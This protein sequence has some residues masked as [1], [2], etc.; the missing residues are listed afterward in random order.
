MGA[1]LQEP[2][3]RIIGRYAIYDQIAS[4]GMAVVHFGRLLGQAGFSRTVAVKRLHP[5]FAADPDFVAMFLDEA[6]LS[7]RVQHP[8]VVAPLDVVVADGELLVIMD[9]VSGETL[10]QLIR[11]TALD[12]EVAPGII[13]SVLVDSLYGLHAAH[14]AL[15]EDGAPLS[16]VHRDVSPQNIIVGVDG[17]ARVLDFGVAKAAMRS[18]ATKDGEIKGKIAYMAPEQLRSQPLDRRADVFAAGVVL[19]EALTGRRLFR[20]DDLG[21]TIERVL[22]AKVPLPSSLNP[23]VPAALDAAVLRALERDVQQR[24]PTAL[25]LAVAI[26]EALPLASPSHVADWVRKVGGSKLAQRIER[27]AA[28]ESRSSSRLKVTARSPLHT[29]V[30]FDTDAGAQSLAAPPA[31]DTSEVAVKLAE[32]SPAPARISK[33]LLAGVAVMAMALGVLLSWWA[34]AGA[35][36]EPAAVARP[37]EPPRTVASALP[38]LAPPE[39]PA[40]HADAPVILDVDAFAISAPAAIRAPQRSPAPK[41]ALPAPVK[42]SATPARGSSCSPPYVVDAKG[43]RRIK[44]ECL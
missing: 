28:I 25:A 11:Q 1:V 18:H 30:L 26:E 24:F 15:G 40:K 29:P 44:P 38:A 27:V 42:G 20:G 8:N 31:A 35:S 17:V 19:W 43:I 22:H 39:P 9:C 14:E 33:R 36:A 32:P 41:T 21:Q 16:I 23:R 5:Q 10:A 34:R 3:E 4:G 7:V 37:P 12:G 6:H 2:S 13:G